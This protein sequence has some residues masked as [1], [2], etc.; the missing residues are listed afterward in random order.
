MAYSIGKIRVEK[1][2]ATITGAYTQFIDV[3]KVQPG[4]LLYAKLNEQD[5]ILQ[6]AQVLSNTQ[7]RL[8]QLDGQVFNPS[9]SGDNLPYGIVQNFNNTTNAR[10][11]K[12]LTEL[13]AKWHR[14]ERELTGW[15]AS[16]DSTYPITTFLGEQTAI[17]T[18][19][20]IAELAQV[21]MSASSDLSTMAQAIEAN[22]QS[23]A[24]VEPRITQFDKAYP[25]VISASNKV[26]TKHDEVVTA[27]N[28]VIVKSSA[29][30]T[31]AKQVSNAQQVVFELK[32]DIRQTAQ[33]VSLDTAHSQASAAIC[34]AAQTQTQ[35]DMQSVN[36]GKTVVEQ[37]K[38]DLLTLSDTLNAAMTHAQQQIAS[39][40]QQTQTQATQKQQA[41]E[42]TANNAKASVEQTAKQFTRQTAAR[43]QNTQRHAYNAMNASNQTTLAL[44]DVRQVSISVHDDL[45]Q[46]ENAKSSALAASELTQRHVTSVSLDTVHNKA[47]AALCALGAKLLTEQ[48]NHINAALNAAL[49]NTLTPQQINQ[50]FPV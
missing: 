22:K 2:N 26:T 4:D 17:P 10:L 14:R 8:A 36:A 25:L 9:I 43:E 46:V 35:N 45:T 29:V 40:A 12:S 11:A 7:L 6:V 49:N 37:L 50:L 31:Q 23:L 32:A 15:F 39:S 48:N 44:N 42:S 41:I 13:Q 3:A 47:Y 20:K 28:D 1:N 16:T 30:A 21:A 38:S 18:P 24:T 5:T 19:T 27:H 33:M 34:A